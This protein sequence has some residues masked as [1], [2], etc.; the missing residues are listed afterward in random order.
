MGLK[1]ILGRFL[2]LRGFGVSLLRS[3]LKIAQ[4]T[5]RPEK[6]LNGEGVGGRRPEPLRSFRPHTANG[7]GDKKKSTSA[8]ILENVVY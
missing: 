6:L 7:N 8:C 2:I 4:I 5:K 1:K 3:K